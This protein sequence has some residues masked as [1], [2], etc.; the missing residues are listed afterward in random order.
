MVDE[1]VT[2]GPDRPSCRLSRNE[3]GLITS[4]EESMVEILGWRPDQLVGSPSTDLIHP[5]D[6]ASAV[7][8]WLEMMAAPGTTKTWRGRYR[9][10]GGGWQWVESF[11]SNQLDDPDNPIVL[12]VMSRIA[13]TEMSVEEDLRA[14]KQIISRLADALPVGIFQIDSNLD[15]TFTN[16]R[17]HD[18]LGVPPAADTAGQFSVIVNQDRVLLDSALRAVLNDQPV[19][20]LELRFG[21]SVP[22]PEFAATRVCQI[23]L[24]PLTD[25]DGSV[26]GAIGCLSDITA[27]VELRRELE[28]RASVDGLTGCLNRSATFE[29]LD[30]ALRQPSTAESGMAVIFVD[31]DRFKEVNDQFGHAA[32]DH[33]L[34]VAADRIRAAV[35]G[36]DTVGRIGGDE[37]LVVCP[38][39]PSPEVALPVARRVA[40]SM[41][42]SIT[43]AE[44]G[45]PIQL[46]ASV[47]VAW[48]NRPSNSAD[49]LVARADRAMYESKRDDTCEVALDTPTNPATSPTP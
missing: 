46:G 29:L 12:S 19:D 5:D 34:T 16:D 2:S 1:S 39:V 43:V 23:S 15:I 33:A 30:L 11:N 8:A 37:F 35:R 47:G 9:T 7:A 38:D 45:A 40:E 18:I 26:T 10:A 4:V 22:H 42:V 3:V 32:G 36:V 41:R 31:L 14:R 6:Q 24:R 17:L 28:I 44:E 13:V 20:D 48:T 25:R 21:V 27:S 49:A